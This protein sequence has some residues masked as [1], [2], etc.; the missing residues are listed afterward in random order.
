MDKDGKQPCGAFER[1]RTGYVPGNAHRMAVIA[2]LV[3]ERRGEESVPDCEGILAELQKID[4]KY[5][6]AIAFDKNSSQAVLL[7]HR[8]HIVAAFRGTDELADWWDNLNAIPTDGLLGQVHKGFQKALE[9]V[10]PKMRTTIRALRQ[11]SRKRKILPRPLWLTG[12]SLGGA[13]ATLAAA[14]LLYHDESFYGVYTFGQPRVGDR[15]FM[16]TFNAEAKTRFFRFQNN[17]DIVTRIP[18][19]IMGYRHVG[20]FIYISEGG[21]LSKDPGLWYR[22]LDGIE[23]VIEDIGENG[24]DGVTDHDMSHYLDAIEAWGKQDPQD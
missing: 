24:V 21:D 13:L 9:D 1:H 12:H 5:E 18:A 10:W 6:K 4:P 7:V 14:E 22:F 15:E 8:D 16:R 17:N 3:Y 19:R 2:K 11:E 20:S 23:G